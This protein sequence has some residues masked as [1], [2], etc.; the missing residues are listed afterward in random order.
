MTP[1]APSGTQAGLRTDDSLPRH[2]QQHDEFGIEDRQRLGRGTNPVRSSHPPSKTQRR[3]QAHPPR[4]KSAI[5]T[6]TQRNHRPHKKN[7][8]TTFRHT[9]TQKHRHHNTNNALDRGWSRSRRKKQPN[10]KTL[11]RHVRID[12]ASKERHLTCLASAARDIECNDP[13]LNPRGDTAFG[14]VGNFE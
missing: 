4:R 2:M 9:H 5:N 1:C 7:K 11:F 3:Y 8:T 13:S 12:S 10:F 6:Q 14:Q